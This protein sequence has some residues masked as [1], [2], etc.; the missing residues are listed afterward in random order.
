MTYTPSSSFIGNQQ[1]SVHIETTAR[2]V[3]NIPMFGPFDSI[4]VTGANVT[5]PPQPPAPYGPLSGTFGRITVDGL[6]NDWHGIPGAR[7]T[8]TI[9]S[10]EFIW[11][12]EMNDD[13]GDGDYTYPTDAT[14]TGGDADIDEFRLAWD[15]GYLYF[16]FKP[17]S[18]NPSASFFTPYF[19]IAID[20]NR[21]Y[22]SGRTEL[23]IE[24]GIAN[25]GTDAVLSGYLASEFEVAI[26]GGNPVVMV[27]KNGTN[28][29]TGVRS[30]YNKTSGATEIAVPLST[31]GNPAGH[32][33][34]FV[35]YAGLET[36]NMLREIQLNRAQWVPGGGYDNDSAGNEPDIFDLVGNTAANQIV[37]LSS[38]SGVT[39]ATIARSAISITFGAI[40]PVELS[41]F[42]AH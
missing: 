3:T 30:A 13:T 35:P 36:F 9:S 29:S 37:D 33:W 7:G 1:Y 10:T 25:G 11:K 8:G 26:P 31:I 39:P 38:Y 12:D 14:F 28:V 21:V 5:L 32:T 42:N 24:G 40:V 41:L 18:V 4:F 6:T 19:G 23:G 34:S 2:A 20:T 17:V 22:G 27:D 15:T 16:L